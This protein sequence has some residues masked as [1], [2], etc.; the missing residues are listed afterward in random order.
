MGKF[1][2]VLF[3][4]AV[5]AGCGGSGS[6]VGPTGPGS[7]P[8][9]AGTWAGSM[10]ESGGTMMGSGTMGGMMAGQLTWQMTST[11]GQVTGYMDMSRFRGTGRMTISGTITGQTM[12]FRMDIPAGGMPEPG[13]AATGN[14]T[15]HMNSTTM[16]GTYSGSN[17]CSGAFA[18]GQVTL[19]RRP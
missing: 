14:G 7:V 2:L 15:A 19:S 11:G 6:S 1:G 18:D 3:L 10:S 13:C 4:A 8:G 16:T 17:T 12:A 5:V 9:Y